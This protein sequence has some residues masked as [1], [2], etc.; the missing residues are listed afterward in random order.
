ML[1]WVVTT[2]DGRMRAVY[3]NREDAEAQR[4]YMAGQ[5]FDYRVAEMPVLQETEPKGGPYR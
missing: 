4:E 1:V 3:S 2:A 5:G